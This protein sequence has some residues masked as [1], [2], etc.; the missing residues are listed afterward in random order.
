MNS[1]SI[2]GERVLLIGRAHRTSCTFKSTNL[3]IVVS[4]HGENAQNI[5]LWAYYFHSKYVS[6]Q[7][8]N[9]HMYLL[10]VYIT[11]IYKVFY[12]FISDFYLCFL[13]LPFSQ[14]G[15]VNPAAQI[16]LAPSTGSILHCPPFSH[17]IRHCLSGISGTLPP[18]SSSSGK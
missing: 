10:D 1:S 3:L 6:S 15:P 16:H 12:S 9:M 17:N 7:I 11:H 2:T 18:E 8:Y 5:F 4:S 13:Y 14:T